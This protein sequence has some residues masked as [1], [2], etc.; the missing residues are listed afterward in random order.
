MAVICWE[1]WYQRFLV[2]TSFTSS[3]SLCKKIPDVDG[4]DDAAIGDGGVLGIK[5][6]DKSSK[7]PYDSSS[8]LIIIIVENNGCQNEAEM[9][10]K[11]RRNKMMMMMSS[12]KGENESLKTITELR[13]THVFFQSFLVIDSYC[14]HSDISTWNL[15]CSYATLLEM[16]IGS[17]RLNDEWISQIRSSVEFSFFIKKNHNSMR[18]IQSFNNDR[19]RQNHV[20]VILILLFFSRF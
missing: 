10:A 12:S 14:A 8:L 16:W 3:L 13:T 2:V 7:L 9:R 11:K 20:V 4:V 5:A 6:L 1:F 17:E 15:H 18:E 19:L